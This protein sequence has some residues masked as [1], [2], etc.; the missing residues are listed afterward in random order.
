MTHRNSVRLSKLSLALV[1]ALAAAPVFAQSTSAGVGGVVTGADGQP[2]AG[3]EVTITHV[4]SG[5]ISRVTTDAN[6][7]YTARGL[8]VGGPYSITVVK[9]GAGA[10]TES[11]IYLDLNKINTV[12]AAL[13][14]D[15]TTLDA[16]TA[17]GVSGGS[18]VFSATKMGSGTSVDQHTI[19]ALPSVNGNIQDYM[20]LDPRVAFIDRASGSM[21]AGGQNPRF[22]SISIDGVSASDTFGL[23]GNN[24]PTRRQ[25]VSLEAIEAIDVNLSNYDVTIAGAAGANVNAVTKSGTN[26]FHGSVYGTYRDGDWFGKNPFG[27][28]FN[29]FTKESTYGATF[30][31]PL[32]KDKLFFFANYEKFEQKAP[33]FDLS[34]TPLGK[35]SITQADVTRAQQIAQGYGIDA[36]SLESN[37]DTNLEE[38]ALKLDWNINDAHRASFRYSKLDQSKLR[39]N[40]IGSTT[41]SLSSY[42]YQ[43]AKTVESYVGQVFSDWTENFSTEFKASYR[44]YS[45]IR[46][47]PT[48]A[49]SIAVYFGGN[50]N[51]PSGDILYLGTEANSQNN[52]LS[53]KTWDFYGAGTLTMGDHDLKFGAQW[54]DNDIYNYFGRNSFGV[55]QFFGLDNFAAGKWSR[56]DWNAETS[57]NSIAAA[58]HN[59]NLGLFLQD[60]WYVNSNLT[61]TLGLRA[62]KPSVDKNPPHVAGV[63]NVVWATTGETGFD[64]SQ[65]FSG[66][67]LFQPRFGFNYTFDSD[68]QM[69]LR[70]GV[71]LFQGDAPQ[72]WLSNSYANAAYF[73]YVAYTQQLRN[74]CDQ[75]STAHTGTGSCAGVVLPALPFSPDGANQ[76]QPTG[77]GSTVYDLSLTGK[78]FD[79][80][81]I[82][83]A[84]LAF[85]TETGWMGTV[86][87]TEILMTDTKTGLYYKALNLG[88][89]FTGP[90]GRTLYYNPNVSLFSSGT[91]RFGRNPT[92]NNVYLID[93]TGKGKSQQLTVSLTKPWSTDSDWSWSLGYTYTNATE[94]GSLT[95]STASS[96]Y[97]YQYSFNT[98]ENLSRTAR[99]EIKD[100]FSG[101]LDWNHKFFGDYTTHVGLVYEGRSGR[102][103]SFVYT[104]DANGDTRTAND[105]FYVPAGKGDVLFGTIVG[106]KYVADAAMESSFFEWLDT[107]A[108]LSQYAGTY[109]PA[110]A[111]RAS[112]VNTFDLRLSQ[113][114]PGLFKGH[115]SQLWVDVQNVGNLLNKKWGD[116]MDYGFF[117]DSRAA[118]LVGID[119]VTHKYV[120]SYRDSSFNND[121]SFRTK[122]SR[123]GDSVTVANGDADGFDQG[124]SQWSV[125]VGFKYEF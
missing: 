106:G 54:S 72:V 84:N 32:V 37:G 35:G 16:V 93:N 87:S 30:G 77:A 9:T 26:E 64:N 80:P 58:Y 14:A 108:M 124:I 123:W 36:G 4:D 107:K 59:R 31:G 85:E 60:T 38:Y 50:E 115:K 97:T 1:A 118:T 28:K 27:D 82:W 112:W 11:G 73:N 98:G 56:Y 15:V 114:L 68:R 6:G 17:V 24:M 111:F 49:P 76:N 92:Y 103:Y 42:W 75:H 10:D 119:P 109:A 46:E 45:A 110:N 67:T 39:I 40:G 13:H 90:D 18:S 117:A 25:P 53:T 52:I 102:P 83:K 43:H 20:R 74:A 62:D 104:N 65:V 125:Q 105:L 33:G 48:N 91:Q 12:N 61:L 94:V 21:S 113:E 44:D 41:V 101:S 55:Y 122:G 79:L 86:F 8:R 3:A 95:S 120:Y 88:P 66:K 29:G 23:E 100:R 22:N 19:E 69:Q 121:G 34:T 99:Y 5:T 47:I 70:G 81:S 96:G 89:G 2:V 78:D 57:P 51:A 63:E 7:R 116:V 71:G